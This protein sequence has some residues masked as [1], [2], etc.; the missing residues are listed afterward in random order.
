MTSIQHFRDA[1]L[2]APWL[3]SVILLLCLPSFVSA[4]VL[5]D[6]ESGIFSLGGT[7]FDSSIQGPLLPIHCIASDRYVEMH[8]NGNLSGADLTLN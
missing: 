1:T 3:T 2:A 7:N 8:I 6:F 5:D 4:Q